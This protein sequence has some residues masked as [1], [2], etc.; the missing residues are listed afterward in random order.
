MKQKNTVLLIK[1]DKNNTFGVFSN[2][3][4]SMNTKFYGTGECFLFSFFETEK[5]H[6]F[7]STGFNEN[8]IYSDENMMA[9][10]CS[11]NYF[12]LCIKDNMLSGY[13]KTTQTFKN[14]CL[15]RNDNFFIV[16]LELW[17]LDS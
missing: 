5:I 3:S 14:P 6:C 13:S 9:F 15:A 16:K 7:H 11:D 8:F 1:D 2:E 4:Y 10:G 17:S 12:S